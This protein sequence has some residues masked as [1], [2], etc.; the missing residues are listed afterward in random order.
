MFAL[1]NHF[2]TVFLDYKRYLL[3][4]LF[5]NILWFADLLMY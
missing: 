2:I 1:K 4:D 3:F 5:L